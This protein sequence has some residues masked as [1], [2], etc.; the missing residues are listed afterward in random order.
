MLGSCMF[1]DCI[2]VLVVLFFCPL[3]SVVVSVFAGDRHTC[4]Y[5]AI[6]GVFKAAAPEAQRGI[7]SPA[8]W[9][10]ALNWMFLMFL[11]CFSHVFVSSF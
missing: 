3:G 11:D 10:L 1:W 9:Y 4:I 6:S 5:I 7:I 8:E 2:V